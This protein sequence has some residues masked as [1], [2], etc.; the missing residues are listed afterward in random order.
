MIFIDGANLDGGASG[1][2]IQVDSIKLVK[3]LSEG[4]K[5]MRAYYYGS[6]HPNLDKDPVI[7]KSVN[8]EMGYYH[9]LAYN[10][11]KINIM[12]RRKRSFESECEKC[13]HITPFEKFVEKGVDMALATD[14]LSLAAA[15]A[16]DVA[17]IVSGDSDFKKVIDDRS[18]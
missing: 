3:A 9:A 12:N 5:L 11:F 6:I 18:Y 10:G 7:E 14:M 17:A 4:R 16:Y 2:G 15:N 1:V 8:D 13:H